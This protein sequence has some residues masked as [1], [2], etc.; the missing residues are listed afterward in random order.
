MLWAA[1]N[2]RWFY[3]EITCR[4]AHRRLGLGLFL[5]VGSDCLRFENG[6][7]PKTCQ[8][9]QTCYETIT[10]SP[11]F[12]RRPVTWTRPH[13]GL[14]GSKEPL[15]PCSGEFHAWDRAARERCDAVL[16][17]PRITTTPE[18]RRF[19]TF[20]QLKCSFFAEHWTTPFSERT[21]YAWRNRLLKV[22]LVHCLRMPL[23]ET[24]QIFFQ[25]G[26]WKLCLTY[27]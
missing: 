21:A 11:V 4:Q 22:L 18:K 9:Y 20:H 15:V 16:N 12:D 3:I 7:S 24:R 13:K 1:V 27:E 14:I 6:S 25:N 17:P 26:V 19:I 2:S 8:A 23:L 5:F 10:L